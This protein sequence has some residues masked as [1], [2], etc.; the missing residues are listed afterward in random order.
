[1]TIFYEDRRILI[2]FIISLTFHII[3][4]GLFG[5]LTVKQKKA[6][7]VITEVDFIE[8]VT[9]GAPP[10]PPEEKPKN[11][12]EF[13]KMA[14]PTLKKPDFPEVKKEEKPMEIVR[15]ELDKAL[16]VEKKLVEKEEPLRRRQDALKFKE[17][18]KEK[19]QKLAEL[20][21]LT[22]GD[23]NKIRELIE[24]EK[25]IVDKGELQRESGSPLQFENEVGLKKEVKVKDVLTAKERERMENEIIKNLTPQ[26]L[27]VDRKEPIKEQ[28]KL[29]VTGDD[30]G[31]K[32]KS[33][34]P[35]DVRIKEIIG[36]KEE[37]KKVRELLALEEKL[38]EKSSPRVASSGGGST[39]IGGGKPKIGYGGGGGINIDKDES[40]KKPEKKETFTIKKTNTTSQPAEEKIAVTP[41]KKS[42]VELSGPLKDRKIIASYMPKYPAWMEEKMIE[43]N[44]SIKFFVSPSGFVKDKMTVET[45]SGYPELDKIV[46]EVLKQWQFEPLSKDVLQEDQW[47]IVTFRFRLQ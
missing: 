26:D 4:L 22:K 41:S 11:I 27:L 9:P 31:I 34:A 19:E 1:M 15:K 40:L 33:K 35:D 29:G 23:V 44:V 32:L 7:K 43:A 18:E 6:L 25:R 8:P 30:L 37:R 21:K 3:V 16:E 39:V 47:G 17:L 46:M 38:V 5:F 2:S 13:M 12:W 28:K 10:G 24:Q 42:T 20:M 36:T 45:T 14:L